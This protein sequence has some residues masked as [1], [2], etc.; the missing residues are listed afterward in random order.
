MKGR[1]EFVYEF[2]EIVVL[3][4]GENLKQEIRCYNN[5]RE[6]RMEHKKS[7]TA[8]WRRRR[9]VC[10]S[11]CGGQLSIGYIVIKNEVRRIRGNSKQSYLNV[12]WP[13]AVLRFRK[14]RKSGGSMED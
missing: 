1:H 6:H 11:R 4:L 3:G 13:P 2:G 14:Q 7:G 5:R 10:V 9:C 8:V 12:D